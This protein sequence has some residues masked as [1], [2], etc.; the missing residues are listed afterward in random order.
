MIGIYLWIGNLD[1]IS[2]EGSQNELLIWYMAPPINL[3]VHGKPSPCSERPASGRKN[4][5]ALAQNRARSHSSNIFGHA[6]T[7]AESSVR[8]SESQEVRMMFSV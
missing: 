4:T 2:S 8:G 6:D 1:R 5:S 3:I 7:D